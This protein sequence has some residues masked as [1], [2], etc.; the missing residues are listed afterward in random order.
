MNRSFQYNTGQSVRKPVNQGPPCKAQSTKDHHAKPSHPRTTMQSPVIQGPPCKAQSTKDHHA[1]PSHPRTTMQSPVIQGP[2]C[3]AQSSKDHHAG[4]IYGLS[5]SGA[6][7]VSR[8][9]SLK[10]IVDC[11][12]V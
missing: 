9:V 4:P 8:Y 5:S 11:A 2:P 7:G 1:K 10:E 3:K 12:C 6:D